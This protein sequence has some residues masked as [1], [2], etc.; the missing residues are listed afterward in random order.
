M[1]E[2]STSPCT[3][4]SS[5][6]GAIV[7]ELSEWRSLGK[8][9]SVEE[10]QD[11]QKPSGKERREFKRYA[12]RLPVRV[13]RI[14]SWR[15]PD[16]QAEDCETEVVAVGGALV[17]CRMALEKADMLIFEYRTFRTRSEVRYVSEGEIPG[18]LRVGLRFLDAP[19]PEDL[20]PP[21]AE[22]LT[23]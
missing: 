15:N 23:T 1:G 3:P 14:G 2:A 18:T 19:F 13:S 6:E 10:Y 12:V 4:G 9:A 17:S 7:L 16:V 8:P 5:P 22:P 11:T 20:I 21:G